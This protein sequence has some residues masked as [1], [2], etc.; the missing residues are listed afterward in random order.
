MT[1]SAREQTAK[2]ACICTPILVYMLIAPK[3][4]KANKKF[5]RLTEFLAQHTKTSHAVLKSW[6]KSYAGQQSDLLV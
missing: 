2:K 4:G 1:D 5:G 6:N 3:T